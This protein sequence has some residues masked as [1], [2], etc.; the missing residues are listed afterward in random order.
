MTMRAVY[1]AR[2]S[3]DEEKQ[4]NSLKKQCADLKECIEHN[5]WLFVDSYV[6]GG[7][8]GTTI[9]KRNEY[10]R[11]CEDITTDKFDIIVIKSQDRLMRNVKD[12]YLF[13][14]KLV[15][16]QK[17]LYIYMENCFYKT[18]DALITGIK[19][20]L[21]AEY[22]RDLSKKLNNAHKRRERLGSSV[23]TNGKMIGYDQVNGEL[24][25]NDKE[26]E[27]VKRIFS[28]YIKGYGT[29]KIGKIL[30]D[31]G[32][33]NENGNPYGYSTISRIL[34]NEKYIGTMICNKTHKDFD[35]KKIIY[36]DESEWI[37]HNNRIPAIIDKDIFYLAQ[38]IRKSKIKDN[39]TDG[40]KRG[41]K[42]K[43]EALSKIL[44]CGECGSSMSIFNVKKNNGNIKK[45]IVC[46]NFSKNGRLGIGLYPEKGCN[47]PNGDLNK[48]NE[49]IYEIIQNISIDDNFLKSILNN[50]ENKNDSDENKNKIKD[51]DNKIRKNK[52][53][54]E[55][56]VDK[57][58]EQLIPEDIYVKKIQNL[59]DENSALTKEK[60]KL[61]NHELLALNKEVKI[62]NIMSHIKEDEF[63]YETFIELLDK[64]IVY[65]DKLLFYIDGIDLPLCVNKSI[66]YGRTYTSENW[67][68]INKN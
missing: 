42:S 65:R 9:K 62:K 49:I 37:I 8:S 20:I 63:K 55:M 11:L 27:I 50:I 28:L 46:L 26:A 4:T 1:Y 39:D 52:E 34:Q 15:S 6:D 13:V 58:I 57:Y 64:I 38:Q 2:V 47:M 66:G 10:N 59:E 56:L 53:K 3:T 30:F 19:A 18:D 44:V 22:S 68:G 36:N 31:D 25:I 43:K 21:A 17:K 45:R 41:K 24:V 16:N 7:K 61:E 12:W 29:V 14:D 32:I 60:E 51:L 67:H 23:M 5:N 54:R 40:R 48:L 35:T 33:S